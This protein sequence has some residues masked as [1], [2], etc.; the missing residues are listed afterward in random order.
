MGQGASVIYFLVLAGG[1]A[2]AA[3]KVEDH[4]LKWFLVGACLLNLV[5]AAVASGDPN[6]A[7]FWR[8]EARQSSP[9]YY[10]D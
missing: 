7:A 8:W 1:L 4:F 6:I 2:F 3:W 10:K 5:G 9:S